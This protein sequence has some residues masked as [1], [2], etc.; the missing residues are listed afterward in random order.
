MRLVPRSLPATVAAVAA[1]ERDGFA[2]TD[3][4][5]RALVLLAR[6]KRDAEIAR[7]LSLSESAV[8]KLVQRTVRLGRGADPVSGGRDHREDGPAR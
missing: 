8:R 5:R 3:S 2:L 7:E 1:A 6:G 4:G